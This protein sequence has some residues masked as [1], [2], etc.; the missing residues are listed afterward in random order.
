MAR[1]WALMPFFDGFSSKIAPAFAEAWGAFRSRGPSLS[2]R[3]EFWFVR[4]IDQC[5][6]IDWVR[7]RTTSLR[8]F[9]RRQMLAMAVVDRPTGSPLNPPLR[10]SR[11]SGR[12]QPTGPSRGLKQAARPF[13]GAPQYIASTGRQGQEVRTL[14][15]ER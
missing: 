12:L 6:L 7:G 10:L 8:Y 14:G 1:K 9:K 15:A 2:M 11:R 13:S 4:E 5:L 3:R